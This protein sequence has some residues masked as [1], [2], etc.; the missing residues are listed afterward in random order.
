VTEYPVEQ[1]ERLPS[2]VEV[3]EGPGPP[4]LLVADDAT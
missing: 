4:D 2:S 3:D 1:S